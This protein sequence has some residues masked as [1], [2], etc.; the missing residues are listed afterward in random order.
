MPTFIISKKVFIITYSFVPLCNLSW[1]IQYINLVHFKFQ[2]VVA[3]SSE[4]I[5]RKSHNNRFLQM[6][7]KSSFPMNFC[8]FIYRIRIIH[9]NGLNIHSMYFYRSKIGKYIASNKLDR[10]NTIIL[11]IT[12]FNK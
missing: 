9:D 7:S 10:F 12:R 8:K 3:A 4:C 2:W 6:S 1:Q 5:L 11:L